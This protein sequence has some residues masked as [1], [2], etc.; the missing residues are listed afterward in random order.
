MEAF[1]EGFLPRFLNQGVDYKIINHQSKAQLLKK[2]PNRL[3]GYTNLPL[4]DQPK[5]LLLVDR[6]RDDCLRLKE[7]LEQAC[8]DV[9]L[10]T[11]SSPAPD[12]SFHVVNRIVIEE[13]EAW[14]FG[15]VPALIDAFPG[16]PKTLA[17]KNG[18]RDPDAVRGGTHEKL[19][20]VL[21][22]A[23]HYIGREQLPKMDVAR[24]IATRLDPHTNASGS[25][26]HFW[27]GLQ[28]L[29]H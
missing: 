15:A 17:N 29:T 26:Q 25:F 12:G 3:R 14:Y 2:I 24:K 5:I 21:Q 28:A 19:L 18:F 22:E 11:K 10:K 4:K 1:L 16:V 23:G 7:K 6:D 20:K 27:T 8:S 13:L 9:G